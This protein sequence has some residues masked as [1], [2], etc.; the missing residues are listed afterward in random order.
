MESTQADYPERCGMKGLNHQLKGLGGHFCGP[1]RTSSMGLWYPDEEICRNRQFGQAQWIKN[2][3]KIA[4][5]SGFDAGYFTK[6]MLDRRLV[7]RIGIKGIDPDKNEKR[8]IK[9]WLKEHPDKSRSAP[10]EK[11]LRHYQK[12]AERLK[13]QAAG[14][15]RS[16]VST[17]KSENQ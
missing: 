6:I 9:T 1:K 14:G 16:C 2:Q 11:Q 13:K 3:K 8:Q 10:S 7:V 5:V 4:K 15:L 12:Q 17:P